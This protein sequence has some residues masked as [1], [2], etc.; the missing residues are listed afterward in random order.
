MN[1][2][3]SDTSQKYDHFPL[4]DRELLHVTFA[5]SRIERRATAT[6]VAHL[7]EVDRR[8]AYALLSYPSLFEYVL[9][10]LGFSE[11]SAYERISAMRLAQQNEKAKQLIAAG[12]LTLTGATQI[13]RFLKEE[14]SA[15]N[16]LSPESQ[17]ELLTAIAGESKRETEKI[18]LS[19]SSAPE[20]TGLKE[21][22]RVATL[23]HTEVKFFLDVDGMNLLNRARELLRADSAVD[24]FT[25]A[26][27]VLIEKK[28]RSLGKM[29]PNKTPAQT[30]KSRP[31]GKISSNLR[32]IPLQFKR[33]IHARSG[34]QCEYI[35][36]LT[37][38]R[39]T[40][41]AHLQVDHQTPLALAGQTEP[42]N[43]RHLCQA[44]NLKAAIDLGL[45]PLKQ[46]IR[47]DL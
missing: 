21:S 2:K 43:L 24:L 23:T 8:K 38:R 35:A 28:E 17:N 27:Q 29:E 34:G 16:E 25:Q 31:D 14:K 26:L 42:K 47:G 4:N 37:K 18:L 3:T 44:H 20:T 13:Q 9:K 40:S 33:Q 1:Q 36:P 5:L 6:L 12:S 10:E 15:G 41:K 11:S 45:L 32:F 46:I 7:E 22:T 19:K 39:C 30:E